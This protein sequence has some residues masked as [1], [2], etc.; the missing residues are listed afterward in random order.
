M[1]L[2]ALADL[3]TRVRAVSCNS[4]SSSIIDSPR[5]TLQ[6]G[7]NTSSLP[8]R[9]RDVHSGEVAGLSPSPPI[10]TASRPSAPSIMSMVVTRSAGVTGEVSGRRNC[11]ERGLSHSWGKGVEGEKQG[12]THW[13]ENPREMSTI[14]GDEKV[15]SI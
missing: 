6:I 1:S 4:T 9:S 7:A 14:Y 5:M 11:S 8:C 2:S 12:G 3:I 13:K 15:Y 10:P